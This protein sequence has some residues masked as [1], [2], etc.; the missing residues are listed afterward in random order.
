MTATPLSAALAAVL[1]QEEQ[2]HRHPSRIWGVPTPYRVVNDISGGMPTSGVVVVGARTSHGKSAWCLDAALHFA[3]SQMADADTQG[4]PAARVLVV[5]P[6][7]TL[8]QIVERA[9]SSM[10]LVPID[11]IRYGTA[12]ETQRQKWREAAENLALN[13]APALHVI[14]GSS[15]SYEEIRHHVE[16]ALADHGQP[17]LRVVVIDYLQRLRLGMLGV[18]PVEQYSHIMNGLKDTANQ[19]DLLV[20]VASQLNRS[21]ERDRQTGEGKERP[22]DLSDLKGSGSI[23]EAADQVILLWRPP[24]S[25]TEGPALLPEVANVV[26]AKNRHGPVGQGKLRFWPRLAAFTDVDAKIN[27]AEGA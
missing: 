19:H 4:R 6:E 3:A 26:V 20:I 9:A 5:S 7:M 27:L 8:P 15:V 25:A 24:N 1:A 14:A 2:W 23:E 10:S 13:L 21:I 17:P 16:T 12:T 11:A 22:P 18:S